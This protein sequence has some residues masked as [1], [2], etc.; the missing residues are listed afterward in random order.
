[1]FFFPNH[2]FINKYDM[3]GFTAPCKLV[4]HILN[5]VVARGFFRM[6]KGREGEGEREGRKKGN[7]E[8]VW[9][10]KGIMKWEGKRIK[11][12]NGKGREGNNEMGREGKGRERMG[13]DIGK[14]LLSI[15]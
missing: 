2:L 10:G 9:E 15:H 11:K 3:H 4:F 8:M 14:K 12:W 1:M 13:W 5:P 6:M 7:K